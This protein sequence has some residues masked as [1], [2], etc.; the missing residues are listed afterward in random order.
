MRYCDKSKDKA[1]KSCVL[2]KIFVVLQRSEKTFASLEQ[3]QDQRSELVKQVDA[4][5]TLDVG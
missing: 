4:V 3:G 2:E 5:V 1:E